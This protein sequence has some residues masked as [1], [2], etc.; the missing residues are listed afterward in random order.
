[1]SIDYL[2]LAVYLCSLLLGV[3][4]PIIVLCIYR[5]IRSCTTG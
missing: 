3:I 4:G 5:N 2:L 1:M